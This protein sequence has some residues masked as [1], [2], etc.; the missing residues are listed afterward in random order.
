[1]IKIYLT[2]NPI[3]KLNVSSVEIKKLKVFACLTLQI[4]QYS[5][6]GISKTPSMFYENL[7]HSKT[8]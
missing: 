6:R 8:K 5:L 4:Y 7:A 3:K 1:M 2:S